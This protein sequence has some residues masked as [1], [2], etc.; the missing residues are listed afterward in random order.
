M[1]ISAFLECS[2]WCSYLK[3]GSHSSYMF[4]T[5]FL[6]KAKTSPDPGGLACWLSLEHVMSLLSQHQ[7]GRCGL[8]GRSGQGSSWLCLLPAGAPPE[9][10]LSG[11]PGCTL[12]AVQ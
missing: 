11:F 8:Y 6:I 12:S 5:P 2:S 9:R 7:A 10:L 3:G 1:A 4:L